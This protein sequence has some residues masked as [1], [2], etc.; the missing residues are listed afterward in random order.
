[1]SFTINIC[2]VNH[3]FNNALD[4]SQIDKQNIKV[5]QA[6][7]YDSTSDI[8]RCYVDASI[9]AGKHFYIEIIYAEGIQVAPKDL[10][11]PIVTIRTPQI[12]HMTPL[13]SGT[14]LDSYEGLIVKGI[15]PA[16]RIY[17]P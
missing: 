7:L 12:F 5:T 3:F 1:M 10:S 15:N 16:I 2:V 8:Y 17:Q 13:S 6:D 4:I 11:A 14:T 9:V